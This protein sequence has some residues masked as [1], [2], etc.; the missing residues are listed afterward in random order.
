MPWRI[1]LESLLS[2]QDC[3]KL[4]VTQHLKAYKREET[5]ITEPDF[6]SN[7]A[8]KKKNHPIFPFAQISF[9]LC[10]IH[11]DKAAI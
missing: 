10:N 11:F 6:H 8:A 1:Y 7:H 9:L 5:E 3:H 4:Q 2:I